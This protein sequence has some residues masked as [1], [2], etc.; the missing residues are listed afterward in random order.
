MVLQAVMQYRL[1]ATMVPPLRH[2]STVVADAFAHT[3]RSPH[4]R[5]VLC[6]F[7]SPA[8]VSCQRPAPALLAFTRRNS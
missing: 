3:F 8:T 6:L 4:R 7:L 1:A 5:R 2:R